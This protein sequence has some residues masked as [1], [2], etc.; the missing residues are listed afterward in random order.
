M[1]RTSVAG[2]SEVFPVKAKTK[3]SDASGIRSAAKRLALGEIRE[4]VHADDGA[5]L[6]GGREEQPI[7]AHRHGSDASLVRRDAAHRLER[8][9]VEE[10]H[11]PGVLRGGVGEVAFLVAG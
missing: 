8:Q 2:S 5:L 1:H 9:G 3:G 4:R 11:V 7:V 6:R 10:V